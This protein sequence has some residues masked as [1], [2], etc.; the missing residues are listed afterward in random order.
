LAYYKLL[1]IGHYS[2]SEID[3][4]PPDGAC[5]LAVVVHPTKKNTRV[6]TTPAAPADYVCSRRG[7]IRCRYRWLMVENSHFSPHKISLTILF[8]RPIGPK[9]HNTFPPLL[10]PISSV[11]INKEQ[12][13]LKSPFSQLCQPMLKWS[14]AYRIRGIPTPPL[15][16]TSSAREP[17]L[18]SWN[19]CIQLSLV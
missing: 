3:E 1:I 18:Q 16:I 14:S 8:R 19:L 13:L 12:K 11:N 5:W 17:K 15:I 10:L 9:V 7:D 6:Q 4:P 2:T